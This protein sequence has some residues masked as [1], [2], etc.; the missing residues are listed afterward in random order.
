M[1]YEMIKNLMMKFQMNNSTPP[2][3]ILLV[4]IGIQGRAV[5]P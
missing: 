5:T 3:L 1:K 4:K 2:N